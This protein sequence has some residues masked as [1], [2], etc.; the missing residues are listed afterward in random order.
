VLKSSII[1]FLCQLVLVQGSA[2][3]AEDYPECI[4]RCDS[5]YADCSNEPP[6][7]EAEVQAAKISA[8]EQK[9]ASCHAECENLKPI[10][11]PSGTEDNPNIIRK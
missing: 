2:A 9:A 6:A 4:M 11:P 5:D 1:L 8:C 10:E 7:P 3:F